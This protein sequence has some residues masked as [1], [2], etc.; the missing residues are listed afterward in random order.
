MRKRVGQIT[1]GAIVALILTATP[2]FA[3][4][5]SRAWAASNGA[6]WL[7]GCNGAP[8]GWTQHPSKI[9]LTC[10]S[11]AI[12][13]DVRWQHWGDATAHGTGTLNLAQGCTPSCATAPSEAERT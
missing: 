10:D 4:G 13:V 9:G 8:Y 5:A 2:S 6:I 11:V 3:S 1:V 7:P 12:I